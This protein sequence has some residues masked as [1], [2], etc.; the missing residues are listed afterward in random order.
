MLYIVAMSA[1]IQTPDV[2]DNNLGISPQQFEELVGNAID[3][4]PAP[5]GDSL[6]NV[7]FVV[8]DEPSPQQRAQLKLRC[9]TLLFGLFEGIPK[10]QLQ[11]VTTGML[12]SKIT[13]FRLPI[14]AVSPTLE[15]LIRQINRTVWHE[16]AHYYGLNHDRIHELERKI[17]PHSLR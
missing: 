16:V 1:P 2:P 5:Y 13:I 17:T 3:N 4:L 14:H 8:E 9:N 11:R 7:V 10:P 6:D 15:H 12:P